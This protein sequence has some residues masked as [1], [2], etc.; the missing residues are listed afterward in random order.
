VTISVEGHSNLFDYFHQ[1]VGEAREELA[2]SVTGDTSLYLA[3]LLADRVRSEHL[4]P[5]DETLAEL[6]ARAAQSPPMEQVQ[7]YRELGDASLYVVG[8]FSESLSRST[9]GPS[10][11]ADMGQAAYDRVDA[12][13]KRWFSNAFG[14]VFREL[15]DRFRECVHILGTVRRHQDRQPDEVERLY[16]EYMLTRSESAAERLR[17]MGLLLPTARPQE[18]G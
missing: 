15:A 11:Y 3:T 18:T 7:T 1:R 17:A 12:G 9:V 5:G 6:H 13:F 4:I 8:Y 10:Y 14:D 2:C 16:A